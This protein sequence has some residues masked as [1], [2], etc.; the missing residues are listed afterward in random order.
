[1]LIVVYYVPFI[2]S[3]FVTIVI[4]V[5]V[6]IFVYGSPSLLYLKFLKVKDN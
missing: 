5:F 6:G 4:K 3:N 2:Y 1:M